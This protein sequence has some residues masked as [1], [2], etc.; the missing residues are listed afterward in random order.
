MAIMAS[1]DGKRN[2]VI[3]GMMDSAFFSSPFEL[4]VVVYTY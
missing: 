3:I 4:P 2:I 1:E